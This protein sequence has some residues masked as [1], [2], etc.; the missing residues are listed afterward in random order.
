LQKR[1]IKN[2]WLL[3]KS[4]RNIIKEKRGSTEMKNKKL[5]LLSII[6]IS[7]LFI[8][9]GCS[10]AGVSLSLNPNPVNFYED[11]T[12]EELALTVKTEGM[13]SLSL[14]NM[15]LEVLDDQDQVI[16]EREKT[17]DIS[18]P[19]IGG[20]TKTES[21]TLDLKNIFSSYFNS[22]EEFIEFYRQK[23]AGETHTLRITV[24]GSKHSSQTAPINY[25]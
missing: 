6:F 12:K 21:F 1:R 10:N 13:G 25:N 8:L 7:V 4:G 23:L 19:V 17:I 3:F 22:D 15:I 16:F 20:V 14:D 11:Q 5:L 2:K 24:T 18:S 9:S